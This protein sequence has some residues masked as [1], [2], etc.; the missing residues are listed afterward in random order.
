MPCLRTGRPSTRPCTSGALALCRICQLSERIKDVM[1]RAQAGDRPLT[2][3][4]TA[5]MWAPATAAL[6]V[7]PTRRGWGGLVLRP[8]V[9]L[10]MTCRTAKWKAP[11]RAS[12]RAALCRCAQ[13]SNS[14]SSGVCIRGTWSPR[15]DGLMASRFN[16]EL[17]LA[18]TN[19]GRTFLAFNAVFESTARH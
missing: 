19:R 15:T 11:W 12:L 5:P 3:R 4:G 6:F 16:A 1:G 10:S 2:D 13:G 18:A 9:V 7:G 17:A 8:F 14:V